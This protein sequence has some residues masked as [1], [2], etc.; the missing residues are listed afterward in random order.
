MKHSP[1]RAA[2]VVIA[3]L[4]SIALSGSLKAQYRISY[5]IGGGLSY[6]TIGEPKAEPGY[7]IFN[8]VR[9]YTGPKLDLGFRIEDNFA[10]CHKNEN[11]SNFNDNAFSILAVADYNFAF[12]G[13]FNPY[14]G[15]EFGGSMMHHQDLDKRYTIC[16][17]DLAVG[18]RI[19]IEIIHHVKLAAEYRYNIFHDRYSY[20]GATL[21]WSLEI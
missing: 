5:E 7:T 2:A 17:T 3:L 20:I 21:S 15:V 9:F 1:H 18:P 10:M 6:Y 14:V 12:R 16:Y 4:F 13:D 19:G 11:K 8:E